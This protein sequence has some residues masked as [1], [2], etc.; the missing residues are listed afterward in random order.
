MPAIRQEDRVRDEKLMPFFKPPNWIAGLGIPQAG[1]SIAAGR[2]NFLTVARK[3]RGEHCIVMSRENGCMQHA[4]LL[5]AA[6]VPHAHALIIA[7][8]EHELPIRR[9]R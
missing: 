4:R 7:A 3:P 9:K 2:Y 1:G 6:Q 5:V 8:R